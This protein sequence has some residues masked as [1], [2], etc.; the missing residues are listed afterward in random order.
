MKDINEI[1]DKILGEQNL[2]KI[3]RWKYPDKLC[4]HNEAYVCRKCADDLNKEDD[5]RVE[6]TLHDDEGQPAIIVSNCHQENLVN[7]R[8]LDGM[9]NRE[10]SV[11]DLRSAIRKITAK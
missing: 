6:I 8:M 4:R 10:V 9:E 3:D 7:I 11:D 2:Y 5:M 1:V